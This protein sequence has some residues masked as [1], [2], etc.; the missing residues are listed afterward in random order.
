M[1]PR[2]PA[3]RTCGSANG[4]R[5]ASRIRAAGPA[6]VARGVLSRACRCAY[7]SRPVW[8]A[9]LRRCRLAVD[10]LL[11]C[12][13]APL[14]RLSQTNPWFRSGAWQARSIGGL[15]RAGHDRGIPRD[16][17]QPAS[18]F[19]VRSV[20]VDALALGQPLPAMV[21]DLQA[22]LARHAS[23]SPNV[24]VRWMRSFS[25]AMRATRPS[26]R[27]LMR[28]LGIRRM[29]CGFG[30]DPSGPLRRSLRPAGGDRAGPTGRALPDS[31]MTGVLW[32]LAD[33]GPAADLPKILM[34]SSRRL[35]ARPNNQ[36]GREAGSSTVHLVRVWPHA[37]AAKSDRVLRWL[38]KRLAFRG[39]L[40]QA[41]CRAYVRRYRQRRS[42]CTLWRSISSRTCRWTISAGW[43]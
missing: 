28:S 1:R 43:L 29:T 8:R 42:C 24:F 10:L 17:E 14:D 34:V 19:G 16:P 2:R 15:A 9:D 25:W 33:R 7:R 6:C 31:A 30:G 5:G 32:G 37:G 27:S 38:H 4:R 41:A 22:E 11:P 12:S 18:G 3:V 26:G 20:V 35:D 40:G 13:C 23:R 39:G 21:P 36:R